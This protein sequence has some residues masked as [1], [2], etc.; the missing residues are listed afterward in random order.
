MHKTVPI[1]NSTSY[2][3]DINTHAVI[4]INNG[5]YQ[6]HMRQR[7]SL[8]AAKASSERYS[9]EIESMKTEINEIKSMIAQ[10]LNRDYDGSSTKA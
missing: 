5:E 2:H 10:L 8:L 4:N 7:A 1:E 9:R 3:R 6:S